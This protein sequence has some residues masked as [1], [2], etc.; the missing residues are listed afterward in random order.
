MTDALEP[1]DDRTRWRDRYADRGVEVEREPSAWVVG[2]LLSLPKNALVLDF[3]G[4]SG[5]HAAAVARSGRTAIVIDFVAGAVA[6]ATAR[7]TNVLGAVADV[8]A[9][10][11]RDASIDAIVVVSFLDRSLFPMIRSLLTP[12]GSLIY[13]TF[14]LQHLDVVGRGK[15]RGPRNA[16]YLLKPGELPY[17]VEPLDVVEHEECLVADG[18]GE[19]HVARMVAIKR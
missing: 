11:V 2:R 16:E 14:T 4:G 15:A 19:R 13:E 12:G 17:L 18:A 9:M 3:A 1:A 7:H 8:R 10:P 5:R 6:A